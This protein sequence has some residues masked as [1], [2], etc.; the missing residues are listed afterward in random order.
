M[1]G[2]VVFR[3]I[4]RLAVLVDEVTDVVRFFGGVAEDPHVGAGVAIQVIALEV[5]AGTEKVAAGDFVGIDPGF[6]ELGEFSLGIADAILQGLA[7][8]G[9]EVAQVERLA[10]FDA[11]FRETP[12]QVFFHVLGR[13]ERQHE[14]QVAKQVRGVAH[15]RRG[16]RPIDLRRGRRGFLLVVVAEGFNLVALL[17]LL[18]LGQ[19]L[20]IEQ[21]RA[22]QRIGDVAFAAQQAVDVQRLPA[23]PIGA[24][25]HEMAAVVAG[26]A[27]AQ[28]GEVLRVGVNQLHRVIAMLFDGRQGQHHR[29][30]AQVHPDEGVGSV[31]I[32]RD[33]RGVLGGERLGGVADLVERRLE[34]R[35]L[36]VHGLGVEGLVHLH[37]REAVQ[38]GLLGDA[39]GFLRGGGEISP[40]TAAQGE[41][42]GG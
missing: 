38:V 32:R 29:L 25:N 27:G 22:I 23:L 3:G 28:V 18:D 6:L 19:V 15:G 7:L 11:D 20:V 9:R 4:D 8:F 10:G 33:E 41:Y 37:H 35:A 40:G 39:P 14:I 30:G 36:L 2:V 12:E 34:V 1:Q 24:G 26:A 5:I 42:K 16:F 31:C 21:L 17:D 13:G